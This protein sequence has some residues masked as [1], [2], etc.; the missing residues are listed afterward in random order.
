MSALGAQWMCCLQKLSPVTLVIKS[1]IST[2]IQRETIQDPW[3]NYWA[4]KMKGLVFFSDMKMLSEGA[5]SPQSFLFVC[6]DFSSFPRSDCWSSAA[7]GTEKEKPPGSWGFPLSWLKSR[8]IKQ[9]FHWIWKK[10]PSQ[11]HQPVLHCCSGRTSNFPQNI[12]NLRWVT[13]SQ[14]QV[15]FSCGVFLGFFFRVYGVLTSKG[16]RAFKLCT[17][18]LGWAEWGCSR[19]APVVTLNWE[20]GSLGGH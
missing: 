10:F 18:I 9:E 13:H 7:N 17:N 4:L 19:S 1:S 16:G 12:W 15:F 3:R 6:W 20:M 5:E 14:V 11:A 8:I 2:E